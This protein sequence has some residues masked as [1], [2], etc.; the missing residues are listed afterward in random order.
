MLSGG[1][2]ASGTSTMLSIWLVVWALRRQGELDHYLD[3][4]AKRVRWLL[5][6]AG[7][8]TILVCCPVN[9]FA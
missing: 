2:F 6:A 5:V 9:T 4:F 8:A 1:F 3:N 7:W